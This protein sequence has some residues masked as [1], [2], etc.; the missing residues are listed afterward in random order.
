M[1]RRRP[2]RRILRPMPSTSRPAFTIVEALVATA[3]LGCAST[4]MV[5]A[6]FVGG[7]VGRRGAFNAATARAARAWV[8]VA[9]ARPCG[10]ADTAGTAPMDRGAASWALTREG[11]AWRVVLHTADGP[12]VR[13]IEAR[14]PCVA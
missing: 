10:A 12:A 8:R 14:V 4:A 5:A 2:L 7:A 11:A 13:T 3:V 6:L 9:A 1:V